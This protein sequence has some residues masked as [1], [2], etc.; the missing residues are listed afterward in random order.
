M[1]RLSL[2]A[3]LNLEC[4]EA[5]LQMTMFTVKISFQYKQPWFILQQRCESGGDGGKEVAKMCVCACMYAVV[6]G[7]IMA[8]LG[9]PGGRW[10]SEKSLS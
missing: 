4:V 3:S 8:G 5:L 2:K 6:M 10:G 7:R 9:G 1:W